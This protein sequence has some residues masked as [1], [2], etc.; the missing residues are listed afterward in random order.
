[1]RYNDL[2]GDG[3]ITW[4]TSTVDDPGDRRIIGN[5]TPRY[6]FGLTLNAAYRGFDAMFIFTGVGKRQHWVGDGVFWGV[7]GDAGIAQKIHVTDTWTPEN[8]DGYYPRYYMYGEEGKNRQTSTR[9]LQSTAYA[10]LK[11]MQIG[12][13]LPQSLMQ[14][15]KCERLRFFFDGEN[16]FTLVNKRINFID[17]EQFGTGGV[18]TYPNYRMWSCG[19]NIQF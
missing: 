10:R 6:S 17:P 2:D 15:F 14:R 7:G 11:N 9:Y 13:T 5:S 12:Y 19:F 8:T 3:K 4:G 18:T 16:V 1:V